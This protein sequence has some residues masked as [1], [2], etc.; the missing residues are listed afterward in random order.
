MTS[1]GATCGCSKQIYRTASI[2]YT[3][4]HPTT[5]KMMGFMLISTLLIMLMLTYGFGVVVTPMIWGIIGD[6][7][8][9]KI[10]RV[11]QSRTFTYIDDFFGAG[12]YND[13]SRT[14]QIVYDT[15]NAVLVGPDGISVKKNVHVQRA[16]R[17]S[18]NLNRIAYSYHGPKSNTKEKLFYVLFS[19]NAAKPQ[20]LAY[21]QCL[22]SLTNL[23]SQV[24]HGM[25]FF[26]APLIRMT[27]R[28]HNNR[29]E[30][31]TRTRNSP[32]KFG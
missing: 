3:G 19:L 27:H 14:Q 20:P 7:L 23:Y 2:N 24:M 18:W 28:E 5:T 4:T 6:A 8:N 25:C 29:P 22:A 30:K 9:R 26:V 11:A 17:N 21:W 15:I 16:S 32:L 13:T 31:P 1:N 12:S 10:N